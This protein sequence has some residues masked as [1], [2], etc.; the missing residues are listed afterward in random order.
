MHT[1]SQLLLDEFMP[2]IKSD[3]SYFL[4]KL[5]VHWGKMMNLFFKNQEKY[6]ESYVWRILRHCR[7]RGFEIEEKRQI[8][9]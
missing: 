1:I 2:L 5:K 8:W 6:S 4:I 3:M 7:N 9:I